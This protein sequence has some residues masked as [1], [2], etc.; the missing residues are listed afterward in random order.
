MPKRINK[1]IELLEQDQ[2]VYM[3]GAHDV[4]YEGGKALAKSW[5]DMIRV[6]MEHG[7]F[8]MTAL[9]NFM[10]GLVDGGPTNSGH[11]TPTIVVELPVIGTSVEMVE[12]NAWMFTQA[13]ATGVHGI[14]L[15][16]A[17]IPEAIK[18]FVEHCRYPFP[19]QGV[20]RGLGPG[21]RGSAGQG[22]A[23]QIWGLSGPEYVEKADVWPLNPDGELLLGLKIEN[24]IA[25]EN[26]ERTTKV[27]G[28]AYA[29]WG[30][31]DMGFSFGHID[32]HD[33]PYPQEM[34][35]AR[36]KI[37]KTCL[38][39]GWAFFEGAPADKVIETI[40]ADIRIIGAHS[41]ETARVGREYTGR[42][43]PV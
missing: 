5:A 19:N 15:C 20:G 8:D 9:R 4:S 43:M 39:A 36:A 25:L 41:E 34:I 3:I 21:R 12:Y 22:M 28:I 7:P 24:R 42:T 29:E 16:H 14:L 13:L 18:A 1:A 17:N 40:D 30:P 31:G 11:R 2:P 10:Q 35:E 37:V 26:V 6:G 27:P 32:A 33:P 38:A 23:G